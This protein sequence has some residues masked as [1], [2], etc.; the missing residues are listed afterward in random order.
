MGLVK[1]QK[2]IVVVEGIAPVRVTLSIWAK[3]ENEALQRLDT[4]PQ[5]FQ[6]VDRPEISLPKMRRLKISIKDAL[7]SVIKLVKNF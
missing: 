7:T 1:N 5:S 3:D 6:F 4:S 2:F